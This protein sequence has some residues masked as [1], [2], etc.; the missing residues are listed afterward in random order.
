VRLEG[1]LRVEFVRVH[2]DEDEVLAG[3]PD[4]DPRLGNVALTRRF[5]PF[6]ASIGGNYD[7]GG[8]WRVGLSASHSERAPSIDELFSK[9]PHG[10]SQAFVV[11]SPDL[12]IE[13]SNGVE[14]TVH[15]LNG[16]VHL[17]ASAYYSRF[18]NFIFQAPTGEIADGLPLYEYFEGKA[19]YYGFELEGDAT[20]GEAMGIK[21]GGE[22]VAD[23]VRAKIDGYGSA[24]QIPPFRV[25]AALTGERGPLS[26]RLEV[27]R[28]AAQRRTAD[29][30]T[31]TPGFTMVNASLD[32]K[33]LA[34]KPEVTLSLQANN[35][36]DVEARRATS[37]LKDFAPLAGRDFRLSIRAGF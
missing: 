32:W 15:H 35:I 28:T 7:V 17:Q 34:D 33:P 20:F 13:K 24:P 8:G 22:V 14:F 23:A 11:G 2:A 30:E 5:T 9:G 10:G 12:G 26:G 25:L 27:E 36:F 37:Q 16:P 6:S 3:E 18:S 31:P 29:N 4:G 19:H 1:G 21:W